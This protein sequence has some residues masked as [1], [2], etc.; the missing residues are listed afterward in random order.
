[1]TNI[2]LHVQNQIFCVK[3]PLLCVHNCTYWT[4]NWIVQN[5]LNHNFPYIK[6]N[7]TTCT[8]PKQNVQNRRFVYKTFFVF[9]V[10]DI[11]L[12]TIIRK[13]GTQLHDCNTNGIQLF[14]GQFIKNLR[15]FV[16]RVLRHIILFI[17]LK[18]FVYKQT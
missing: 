16:V 14:R 12:R 4:L 10:F 9:C 3:N 11:V 6:L 18:T 15:K 5:I 7:K 13:A 17:Y 1:M 8:I 2:K